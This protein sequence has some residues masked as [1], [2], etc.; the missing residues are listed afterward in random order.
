MTTEPNLK[1]DFRA[2]TASNWSAPRAVADGGGGTII[3]TVEVA[4]SPEQVFQALTTSEVEQWWRWPGRYQQKDWKAELR[5]RGPWSVT[6]ELADGQLVH[7]WGEFCELNFP[8]RIVMTR[9]F[10]AHPFLGERETT[11]TYRLEPRAEG[12][13]VTVR[14]EGFIGRTEAAYGNAEIWE[15]VLGWLAGY[16]QSGKAT[17]IA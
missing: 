6:V 5:V 8:N 3:A 4:A 14:D 1:P 13:L 15:R 2:P 7:A 17:D 10:D 12:T 16:W 9:R 11:I